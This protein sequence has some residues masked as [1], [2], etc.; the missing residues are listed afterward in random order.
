M[1]KQKRLIFVVIFIFIIT[2]HFALA[3]GIDRKTRN[4]VKKELLNKKI[5]IVPQLNKINTGFIK[6]GN[7]EFYFVKTISKIFFLDK[8]IEV[9][10]KDIDFY[11]DNIK[12][13]LYH[14]TLGE[15]DIIVND[16]NKWT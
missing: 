2:P 3:N 13:N 6:T 9:Q 10:V 16:L 8:N 7:N 11:K 12:L 14:D 4:A 15:G 1:K 5:T